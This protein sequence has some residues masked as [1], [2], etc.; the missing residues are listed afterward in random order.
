MRLRFC[1]ILLPVLCAAAVQANPVGYWRLDEGDAVD[2]GAVG[3]VQNAVSPGLMDGVGSANARFTTD[4]PGPFIYDP[5][6]SLYHANRF[7]LDGGLASATVTVANDAAMNV[8][9]GGGNVAFTFEMFIKLTGEP[10]AYET[11]ARRLLDG[12]LTDS[13]T[14]SDREGWML[15]FEH[16]T[17][18]V[19][20]YGRA[21]TR[22]DIQGTP[23]PDFNR[24]SAVNNTYLFV[25]TN[26][27]SGNPNDYSAA[28]ADPFLDGDGLNDIDQWMHFA[29]TFDGLTRQARAY[30]TPVGGATALG[31]VVTLNGTLT[32]PNAAIIFGKLA[33]GTYGLKVDEVRYSAGVLTPAQFLQV[34]LVPEPSSFGLLAVGLLALR[35]ARRSRAVGLP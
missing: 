13:A 9:D 34:S 1:A 17:A 27:G 26:S 33:T 20:G 6:S 14:T 8:T 12:P 31:N 7:A 4:V 3:A 32:H 28:P 30:L 25:D 22:F 18:R 16:G 5:V 35:R 29:I 24:V 15:D 11:F 10:A 23:P 2:G 21:R 19:N